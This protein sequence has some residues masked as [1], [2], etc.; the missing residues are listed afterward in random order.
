MAII[1]RRKCFVSGHA[2]CDRSAHLA[3]GMTRYKD[4]IG[5]YCWGLVVCCCLFT[6]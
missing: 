6:F 4:N 2:I 5:T 1:C 3:L